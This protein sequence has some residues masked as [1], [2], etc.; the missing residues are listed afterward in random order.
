MSSTWAP[1]IEGTPDPLLYAQEL[2]H[3][4]RVC[5]LGQTVEIA[6]NSIAIGNAAVTL[7]GRY[8]R[9]F[10]DT[11]IT[12][13]IAVSDRDAA[14]VP[15]P[16]SVPRGQG[17]LVS[18]VCGPDNFG[19]ADLIQGFGFAWL[20]RDV[21]ASQSAVILNFLEP[22][23]YM[24]VAARHFAQVHAACVSLD[25]R[26]LVLCGGSGAGKT[27]LAYACARAGW[28][29]VSGDAIQII[30]SSAGCE[31]VGRPHHI[32]FRESATALFP[33]LRNRRSSRS[34][35]GKL[36]IAVDTAELAIN[37]ALEARATHVVFLNRRSGIGN[38]LFDDVSFEE[39]FSYLEQVV[40]YG[41]ETLRAAQKKSLAKL[42]DRPVLRLTYS[43]L[44]AAEQALRGLAG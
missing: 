10:A 27:C 35:P 8:P 44:N 18:I 21:A 33:E 26:A 12:L 39:A 31:I 2:P 20:T 5:P 13:R 4:V 40:F 22:L 1:S 3:V 11:P 30:R 32:R 34:S 36:D 15:H 43:D 42:L 41:D 19:V 28:Q 17:H 25:G 7:W 16:P 23:V 24:M 9:L 14:A 38:P 6:T 29:F 37:V